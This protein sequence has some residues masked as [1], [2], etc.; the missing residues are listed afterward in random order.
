MSDWGKKRVDELCAALNE[1]ADDLIRAHGAT[2]PVR[3]ACALM[4]EASTVI[5]DLWQEVEE[6][7]S[8][9][10]TNA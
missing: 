2:N 3:N 7:E 4:Y 10:P 5:E 9:E 6:Y 8:P 1:K